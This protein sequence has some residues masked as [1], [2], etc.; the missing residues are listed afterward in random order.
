M[1]YRKNPWN[2]LGNSALV[3]THQ[4][5]QR[6]QD[7]PGRNKYK[8]VHYDPETGLCEMNN[9]G[10][11]G[12]SNTLCPDYCTP[13]CHAKQPPDRSV[14]IQRPPRT[15]KAPQPFSKPAIKPKPPAPPVQKFDPASISVGMTVKHINAGKGTVVSIDTT[16]KVIVLRIAGNDTAFPFP[17]SFDKGYL[18]ISPCKDNNK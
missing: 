4:Y 6:A 3:D 1:A 9:I 2:G 7:K 11:V 14:H 8:C 5:A 18:Q 10:C 16:K 15:M 13:P 17:D 12:P